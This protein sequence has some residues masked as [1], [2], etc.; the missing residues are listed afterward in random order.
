[1]CGF[2]NM[3]TTH[4]IINCWIDEISFFDDFAKNLSKRDR[5]ALR[6]FLS[7]PNCLP[8]SLAKRAATLNT[9]LFSLVG[10]LK[11]EIKTESE[12]PIVLRYQ[13]IIEIATY[14]HQNNITCMKLVKKLL[15]SKELYGKV[16]FC[17]SLD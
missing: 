3:K 14:L 12:F 16:N 11:K 4:R 13:L 2:V 15:K 7:H 5:R 9:D 10:H 6:R 17:R 1:M 8:I